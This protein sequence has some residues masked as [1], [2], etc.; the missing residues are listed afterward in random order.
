MREPRQ[1]QDDVRVMLDP[2]GHPFCLF[3]TS[4][5]VSPRPLLG[6]QAAPVPQLPNPRLI[7]YLTHRPPAS[8]YQPA[9]PGSPLKGPATRLVIQPP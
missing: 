6:L 8:R 4:E 5:G 7:R 2:A 9:V 3:A 1:P